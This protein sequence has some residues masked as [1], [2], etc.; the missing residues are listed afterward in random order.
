M[1]MKNVGLVLAL[2]ALSAGAAWA[3]QELAPSTDSGPMNI[4]AEGPKPDKD[5]V[6]SAEPGI[7]PPFVTLPATAGYPA[8]APAD[9]I[10]GWSLLSLVVGV[11]G[12][13]A[14]IQ[15]VTSH[16]AAFDA[17][18]TDAIK[19]FKFEPGT[20]DGKPVPVRVY[21]RTRFFADMRPAVTR[22]LM[23]AGAGGGF[24]PLSPRNGGPPRPNRYRD[25][26]KPPVPTKVGE[27]EYSDEARRAKIQGVVVVSVLVTEEGF[28]ADPRVEKSLGHGLD[29]KA[30]ECVQEYRF[31]PAMKDGAPVE[32]RIMMEINFRL[33]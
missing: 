5:G 4:K 22:I 31:K 28:P 27:P 17:A 23:R 29:E 6:Y 16:G 15:V 33:Y 21:A 14:N 24:S 20:L 25:Y 30:L 1:R 13:P 2:L 12:V 26:D 3:Q 18:A 19:Q 8:H 9:S 11:D 10:N 32:A 7:V